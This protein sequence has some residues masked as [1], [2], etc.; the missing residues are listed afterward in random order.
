MELVMV[1]LVDISKYQT[2]WTYVKFILSYYATSY[3]AVNNDVRDAN[4]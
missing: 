3:I 4:Q 2:S 1:L